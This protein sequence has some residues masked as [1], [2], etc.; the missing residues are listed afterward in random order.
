[1]LGESWYL[2]FL[3]S[4]RFSAD[5]IYQESTSDHGTQWQLPF[6]TDA[7]GIQ[8]LVWSTKCFYSVQTNLEG[9]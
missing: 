6:P 7:T 3:V 9:D 4:L 2:Y 1:M 8:V 5:I